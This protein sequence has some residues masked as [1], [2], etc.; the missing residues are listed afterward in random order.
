MVPV[1]VSQIRAVRSV[2]AVASWVPSGEYATAGHRAGVAVRVR[3]GVPVAV[4]QVRAVRSVLA[5]ASWVPSGAYA[6][7]RTGPVWL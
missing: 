4:S 2:L 1:A 3:R 5:V 7:A 6:M